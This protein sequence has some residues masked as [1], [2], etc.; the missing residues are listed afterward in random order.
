[1]T[2]FTND[3]ARIFVGDKQMSLTH[4]YLVSDFSKQ[5]KTFAY[6]F[7]TPDNVY[8]CGLTQ[9]DGEVFKFVNHTLYVL[10]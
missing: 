9:Y 10:G 5:I 2:N 3:Y 7:F 8:R 6:G 4:F 1:M